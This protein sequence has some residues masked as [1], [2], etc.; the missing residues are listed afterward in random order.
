MQEIYNKQW[1]DFEVQALAYSILRKNLYPTY[2]VRG[3]Y[4]F[5]ACRVGIAVFKAHKDKEPELMVIV[6]IKK[7]MSQADQYS[8]IL[9]VPTVYIRGGD[10]A[11]NIV[12]LVQPYLS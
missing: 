5:N 1:T 4:K 10:E 6:Q 8:K 9:G 12:S 2:L 11:Y 3:D 7:N